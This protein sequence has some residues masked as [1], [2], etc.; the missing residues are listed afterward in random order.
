MMNFAKYY[1]KL[2][3]RFLF[4][5]YRWLII[6]TDKKLFATL[7]NL[8]SMLIRSSARL[9]WEKGSFIFKDNAFPSFKHRIRHQ[10]QCNDTYEFG[11]KKKT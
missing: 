11:H 1:L 7:F 2:H 9:S 4:N 5:F 6:K 10:I 8:K 3:A